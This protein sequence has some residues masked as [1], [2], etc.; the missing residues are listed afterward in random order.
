MPFSSSWNYDH[1]PTVR[2]LFYSQMSIKYFESMVSNQR[3]KLHIFSA[4]HLLREEWL[5]VVKP[6]V[7]PLSVNGK[8]V[9][10]S[11][12][13]DRLSFS[14]WSSMKADLFLFSWRTTST[15]TVSMVSTSK[16]HNLFVWTEI[17]ENKTKDKW[18]FLVRFIMLF[19]SFKVKIFWIDGST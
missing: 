6:P 19:Y 15:R 18:Q 12:H 3:D 14:L 2:P 16:V 10:H 9:F 17:W 1:Y 11:E 4:Y 5:E 8:S 13:I 7:V